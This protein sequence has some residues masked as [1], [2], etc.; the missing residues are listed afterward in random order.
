MFEIDDNIRRADALLSDADRGPARALDAAIALGRQG[1]IDEMKRSGLRGRG[2][3]G[4]PTGL[5]WE[6]C[7]NAPGAERYI[8]C[9]ADEGEPGTFKDRVLLTALASRVF[10]GMAIAGYAVGATRGFLYLRGEYDYLR[11]ELEAR[12]RRDARRAAGSAS[13]S[14]A[15]PASIS[16]SRSTWAPAPISAARNRR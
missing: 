1:V 2:G 11:A 9:N 16:T 6:G 8:V 3:A 4:F 13:R 14:A 7:R 12:A 5:K 10:E 15:R